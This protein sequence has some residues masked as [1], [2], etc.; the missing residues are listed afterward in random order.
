MKTFPSALARVALWRLHVPYR[1]VTLDSLRRRLL[2]TGFLMASPLALVACGC[3]GDDASTGS[4]PASGADDAD[5]RAVQAVVQRMLSDAV[6]E[7]P[8]GKP[9]LSLTPRIRS[10]PSA[11]VRAGSNVASV[12]LEIGYQVDPTF[13]VRLEASLP[14]ALDQGQREVAVS[15]PN[16]V[17]P[18]QPSPRSR[19]AAVDQSGQ[20]GRSVNA[21]LCARR[22]C[23]ARANRL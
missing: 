9:A 10:H 3:G 21:Q 8:V 12:Q 18:T 19:I 2:L 15:D 20:T 23:L 7:L 13:G 14:S 16:A 1:P 11:K 17:G 6:A 22:S 5:S 4:G